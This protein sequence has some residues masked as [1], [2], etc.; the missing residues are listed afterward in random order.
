MDTRTHA[1]IVI[2][3]SLMALAGLSATV[4]SKEY[5]KGDRPQ[6]RGYS[7]AVITEGGKT[8]WLAGQ[9]AT[10]DD[11][12]YVSL[13][14]RLKVRE[15]GRLVVET[16]GFNE[17]TFI[18]ATGAPHTDE[19]HTLE[20]LRSISPTEIEDVVT[21]HDPQYYARDWQSRFVYNLRD[22]VRLEDYVCGQPHRNLSAVAGV[23]RPAP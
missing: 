6:L 2:G 22:D 16:A 1:L 19:M 11:A 18:D 4:E 15:S 20:R 7:E 14:G 23:R 12:G 9:T 3:A 21:I 5:L 17:K 8:V 13:T 10:M